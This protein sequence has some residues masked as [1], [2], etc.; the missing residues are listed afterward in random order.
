MR[1]AC[2][3]RQSLPQKAVDQPAEARRGGV[4]GGADGVGGHLLQLAGDN[5]G[6]QGIQPIYSTR[7]GGIPVLPGVLN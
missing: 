1:Q 3:L 5:G 7:L 2:D 4:K 6:E